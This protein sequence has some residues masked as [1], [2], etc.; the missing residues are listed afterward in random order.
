MAPAAEEIAVGQLS[1]GSREA[2]ST[3][4]FELL[5]TYFSDSATWDLEHRQ[6][7]VAGDAET[8]D[9]AEAIRIRVALSAARRLDDLLRPI[10]ERLS[11][12][13][14]REVEEVVGA[15]RG[16]L[17]VPRYLRARS[18]NEVPRR[19]PVRVLRRHHLT[20]ENVL[21]TY[22]AGWV[23]HE[24][25]N[26][27]IDE[28]LPTG[29]P[30]RLELVERR[31]SLQRALHHPVL[32]PAREEAEAVWCRGALDGL[33]DATLAR[34]EGGHVAN[35]EPYRE[36]VEWVGRFDPSASAAGEEIEWSVYGSRFDPKLFEIWM[37]HQI[38]AAVTRALG[39]APTDRRPLWQRG[40]TPTYTWKLGGTSL[41]L[42]FQMSLSGLGTPRWHWADGEEDLR[43]IPDVIA[44]VSAPGSSERAALVDAKLRQRKGEPTEEIYKLLG[45]FHN[46]GEGGE[47]PRGAIVAYAPGE[48]RS[49]E[50]EDGGSGR[51]LSIGVDPARRDAAAFDALAALLV[52]LLDEAD[53][54][55]RSFLAGAAEGEEALALVQAR[56]V[57]ALLDRA[58]ALTPGSLD[59]FERLLEGQLPSIWDELEPQPRTM[60]V[61]A[62]Y[63]GST[64]PDGADLS[65]PVLGLCA[66]CERVLC[67]EGGLLERLAIGIPEHVRSPVTLG[68]AILLKKAER[69]KHEEGKAVRA[70]LEAEAELDLEEVFALSSDLMRLNE[71][72]R[73][74]AHTDV[75]GR[76]RW[77]TCQGLVL[78]RGDEEGAGLLARLLAT[79][80][81]G[82]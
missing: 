46:R 70:F 28:I 31:G 49:R 62:E 51:V 32:A 36:M 27:R 18:R 8:E 7:V 19:Y 15:I 60:L 44:M 50:L 17:D 72:R 45:Y 43:G 64:A 56:V 65:G 79:R 41:R 55:A 4:A 10:A 14:R 59:P 53:P 69:A 37:L 68:A 11:F 23:V 81:G 76:E 52:E 38:A 35:P 1:P 63:F 5:G 75:I 42:H 13:Y 47:P 26:L 24:I 21:A 30:E 3:T 29:S 40:P 73:A 77:Q 20:P 57:E 82:A 54:G 74:A 16:R 61:S 34:L 80:P 78:G 67:T 6:Q 39:A 33:L 71:H 66:A 22:A 48:M 58:H 9:L 2:A 12:R 25:G